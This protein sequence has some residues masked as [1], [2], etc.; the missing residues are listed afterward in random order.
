MGYY[1]AGFDVIGVDIKPQ[2]QYP[3]PIIRRDGLSVLKDDSILEAVDL[4]HASPPCQSET[5]LRFVTKKDYA[6]LLTPTLELLFDLED[7]PWIVE[8]VETTKKMPGSTVLCGTHF[9]L[10]ASG[11]VLKRHRRFSASFP[12]PDPG[13]C[14]CKANLVGG[15]YGNLSKRGMLR[16]YKFDPTEARIAMGIDWMSR[17][18]LA[19]AI[20]PD[21]TRW[22]AECVI[23]RFW[24]D[25][26]S[27]DF[28][29]ERYSSGRI[30]R[31]AKL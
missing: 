5:Q 28:L 4:I 12:L 21:Y 31:F 10:I 3:F 30:E 26:P 18:G 8:N 6:D 19:Q 15:V 29:H 24:P 17:K 23:N 16:G 20:P 22:I 14:S 27:R 7:I 13:P 25:L 2:A 11:R 1:L 9:N